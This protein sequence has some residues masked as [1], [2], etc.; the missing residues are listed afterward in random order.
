MVIDRREQ[1]VSR[2]NRSPE[3]A[4]A[5]AKIRQQMDSEDR[6]FRMQLAAVREAGHLTQ[7]ELARRLGKP[8]GNV[9]RTEHAG[10]MLFS[11]LRAY[12][13]AAGAKDVAITAT[14]GG[15]RIEVALDRATAA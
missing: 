4:A 1:I 12:L 9:S 11:T 3:H 7:A 2:V 14:V 10:D 15:R 6:A 5:V 13:E 8:Q